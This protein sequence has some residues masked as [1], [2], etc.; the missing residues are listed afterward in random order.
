MQMVEVVRI[1]IEDYAQY[2]IIIKKYFDQRGP[3]KPEFWKNLKEKS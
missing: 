1:S 2:P 3:L